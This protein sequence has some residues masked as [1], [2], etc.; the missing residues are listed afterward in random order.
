MTAGADAHRGSRRHVRSGPLR[1]SA[2]RRR[3]APRARAR[4]GAPRAGGAILRT[5]T[6]PTASAADRLAMLE[7]A[8]AEFP[9]LVVDDRELR[10][11]GKSYTVLTLRGIARAS[12]PAPAARCCS[13]RTRSA[14]LPSWHRW[15]DI[16]RPRA[17]RRRRAARREP[18]GRACPRRCLPIWREQAWSTIRRSCVRDRPARSSCSPSRP[19]DVS[20][21]AIRDRSRMGE[22]RRRRCVARFAPARRFGLY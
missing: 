17:S 4:R 16:V 15:R 10:R 2:L 1:A 6:R 7:L 3:R 8:V 12:S 14:G 21:T 18:R 9:G 19:V 13:A 5:A 20:A 22:R 11:A